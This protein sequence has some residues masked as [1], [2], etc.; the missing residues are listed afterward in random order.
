[1]TERRKDSVLH[2]RLAAT[3][4]LGT[5]GVALRLVEKEGHVLP[6]H[7]LWAWLAGFL[8]LACVFSALRF[9]GGAFRCRQCGATIQRPAYTEGSHIT[10]HCPRCDIEWDTGWRVPWDVNS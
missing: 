2:R 3:A 6:P 5:A 9:F 1:M 4:L 8:L 10:F 7:P